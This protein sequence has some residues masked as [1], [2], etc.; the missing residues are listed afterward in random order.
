MAEA[1]AGG[2]IIDIILGLMALEAV[3]LIA[4]RRT[5]GRGPSPLEILV[6][7]AAGLCLLIALGIHFYGWKRGDKKAYLAS[8]PIHNL[9]IL[10]KLYDLSEARFFD[11]YEQG[12]KFLQ[13]F[14][15]VLFKGIDRPIDFFYEKIVTSVGKTFTGI[16][17]KAHNGHY[18]NYL[19]WCLAGLLVIAGAIRLLLK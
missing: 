9:P 15:L 8:E 17:K 5:L 13:S 11:L 6:S 2:W 3:A 12:V 1:F 16:L 14:S 19:A 18:A 4:L 10:H 7:L